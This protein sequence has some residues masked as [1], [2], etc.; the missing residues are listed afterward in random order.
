MGLNLLKSF[1]L[2]KTFDICSIPGSIYYLPLFVGAWNYPV[3]IP[4]GV[5]NERGIFELNT[6]YLHRSKIYYRIAQNESVILF[7]ILNPLNS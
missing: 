3:L 2:T 7:W 5:L 6:D 4:I 1:I